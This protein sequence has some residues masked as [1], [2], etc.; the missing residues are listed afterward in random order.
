MCLDCRD[1]PDSDIAGT[2]L[3]QRY[4]D[5]MAPIRNQIENN[6]YG[7]VGEEPGKDVEDCYDADL[8]ASRKVPLSATFHR[9]TVD[10]AIPILVRTG[11]YRDPPSS[12]AEDNASLSPSSSVASFTDDESEYC[13][14]DSVEEHG[15]RDFPNH[16]DLKKP[17]RICDD[18]DVAIEY[19]LT[20]HESD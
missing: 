17:E 7:Q 2:N 6:S 1:T 13:S 9:Q 19:I 20:R 8:P 5:R 16:A 15:H 11:V 4:V 18:V 10:T 12:D 3:Y 14:D